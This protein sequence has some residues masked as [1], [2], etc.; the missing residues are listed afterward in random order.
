MTRKRLRPIACIGLLAI[1]IACQGGFAQLAAD[2]S[3][4]QPPAA[5]VPLTLQKAID[6]A[7]RTNLGV[8]LSQQATAATRAQRLRVL[9]QLLPN[10]NSGISEH[11]AKENLDTFGI[12]APGFPSVVGP[13]GFFDARVALSQ[14]LLDVSS[15]DRVRA[16]GQD[17]SA[18]LF[19]YQDSRNLIVTAAASSYLQALSDASRISAAQAQVDTARA[20]YNKAVDMHNAGITPAID[21][22]R[23]QVE[24]QARQQQLIVAKNSYSKDLLSIARVIGLPLAQGLAIELSEKFPY[25]PLETITLEQAIARAASTRP[26][27]KS[28]LAQVRSAELSRSAAS[29]QRLPRLTVDADYGATG[30]A[31]GTSVATFHVIGGVRLPIFEGGRIHGDVLQADAVLQQQRSRAND[32][33]LQVEFEVRTAFLDLSSTAD[34][35]HVTASSVDLARQALTQSQDRFASGVTDNLEVVQAQEAFANANESYIASLY[36]YNISKL[37]LARAL[38]VAEGEARTFVEGK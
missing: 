9:S 16:A 38:G 8:L 32:L 21:S 6:M 14:S 35:V 10:I 25:A 29:A 30:I 22:V 12:K 11:V 24:L 37:S 4:A 5:T 20:L 31:P 27:L 2:A 26:D 3:Q 33:R 36:A 34:Q 23:A 19:S 28:A 13:F 18:A 7:L 17:I 15:T 1:C